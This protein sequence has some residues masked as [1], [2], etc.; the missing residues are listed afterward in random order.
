MS[1]K[2][3][4]VRRGRPLK[5]DGTPDMRERVRRF[6]FSIPEIFEAMGN[7]FPNNRFASYQSA[8]AAAGT[9][10]HSS[11]NSLRTMTYFPSLDP[12]FVPEPTALRNRRPQFVPVIA[13][14]RQR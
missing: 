7:A 10:R 5:A 14:L 3:R 11:A 1:T 12:R 2:R 13:S 9:S 8:C 4:K 6:Y